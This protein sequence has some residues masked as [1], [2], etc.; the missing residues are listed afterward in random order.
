MEINEVGSIQFRL[1]YIFPKMATA[2]PPILYTPLQCDFCHSSP[3][4][5]EVYFFSLVS[6]PAL[7]LAGPET[8]PTEAAEMTPG[9]SIKRPCGFCFCSSGT[10]S[11]QVQ[12]PR[13]SLQEGHVEGQVPR[14]VTGD[15]P[16]QSHRMPYRTG[17]RHPSW[18]LP[19]LQVRWIVS[20]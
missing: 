12:K 20:K 3:P 9:P 19:K 10:L 8:W 11:H 16:C 15:P 17:T 1:W 13:L 6:R 5:G 14:H 18:G 2:F 7:K 4:R